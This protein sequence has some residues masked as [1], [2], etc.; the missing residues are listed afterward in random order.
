[1]SKIIRIH[2]FP[3]VLKRYFNY[4]CRCQTGLRCRILALVSLTT[5]HVVH[6]GIQ[7]RLHIRIIH[8]SPGALP[9]CSGL[10]A[11]PG[12]VMLTPTAGLSHKLCIFMSQFR[13]WY[14]PPKFIKPQSSSGAVL[15][16]PCQFL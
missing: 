1:M 6:R 9:C 13:I 14:T 15:G 10:P 5:I 12:S 16:S 3:T 4:T 2:L 11:Y 7:Q 8:N